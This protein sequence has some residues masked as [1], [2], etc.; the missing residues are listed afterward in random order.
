YIFLLLLNFQFVFLINKN[1]NKPRFFS[2]M[3]LITPA[4]GDNCR[5]GRHIL[6]CPGSYFFARKVR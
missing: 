6:W 5:Q 4:R 2:G 1:D 3:M